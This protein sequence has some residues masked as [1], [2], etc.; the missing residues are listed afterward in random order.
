MRG[1]TNKELK[2]NV[3]LSLIGSG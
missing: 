1:P 3:S 2:P